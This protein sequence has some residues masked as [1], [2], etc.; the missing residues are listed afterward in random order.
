MEKYFDSINLNNNNPVAI[1]ACENIGDERQCVLIYNSSFVSKNN[2]GAVMT[3]V[4]RRCAIRG[5]KI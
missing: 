5:G 2:K 1:R 3:R 4:T